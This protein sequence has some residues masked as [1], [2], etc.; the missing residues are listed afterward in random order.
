VSRDQI[1]LSGLERDGLNAAIPY[2]TVIQ[3]IPYN[4]NF[5]GIKN[6]MKE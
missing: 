3:R 2:G 5:N 4:S 6:F 1:L